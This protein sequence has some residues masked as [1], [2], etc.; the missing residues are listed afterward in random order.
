MHYTKLQAD[1]YTK[2]V[3][4]I[5][6]SL[7]DILRIRQ[8]FLSSN[9]AT[10]L[11][12][13]SSNK[14]LITLITIVKQG[15]AYLREAVFNLPQYRFLCVPGKLSPYCL[16]SCSF[17]APIF[18]PLLST[19][20]SHSRPR[21]RRPNEHVTTC[22]LRENGSNS[23]RNENDDSS[24]RAKKNSWNDLELQWRLQN[25]RNKPPQNCTHCGGDGQMECRACNA[26]GL[27]MFGNSLICTMDGNCNCLLCN[28]GLLVCTK[29]K[30]TG[31]I[32]AWLAYD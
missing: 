22:A 17:V 32:A 13:P 28:G 9:R 4:R 30:G 2:H 10:F 6:T 16:M 20:C 26:T 27:L 14:F 12:E 15:G 24:K 18:L 3:L 21:F 25:F 8:V 11:I 31:K 7:Y 29:C 1:N 19:D 23:S 5:S